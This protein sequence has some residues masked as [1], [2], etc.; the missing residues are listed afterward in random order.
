[1]D[2]IKD[3]S[4]GQIYAIKSN[5]TDKIYIGST[6]QPLNRRF[7]LH[8]SKFKSWNN[9]KA[10]YITSF[11]IMKFDDCIIYPICLYPC[12]T[13]EE[14]QK[15]E[16]EVMKN[17]IGCINK[18]IPTRTQKEYKEAHKDFYKDYFKEY[19]KQVILCACGKQY[20]RCN[21][22]NHIKTKFHTNN[23]NNI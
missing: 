18:N 5:Q 13:K 14:L 21:K 4:N 16:A 17:T 7:S 23:L 22:T 20:S 11:D 6:V 15:K 10:N 9:N 19:N 2:K 8:K 12:N 1:M 3:Y